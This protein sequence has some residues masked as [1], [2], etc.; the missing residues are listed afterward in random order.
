MKPALREAYMKVAEVFATLSRAKRRK[1]GAVI[2][3]IG[4][5][6]GLQ[7]YSIGME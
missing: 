1:V 4:I 6:P 5:M 7:R 3:R 2:V